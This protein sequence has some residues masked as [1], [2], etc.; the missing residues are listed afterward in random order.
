MWR[1][2][3]GWIPRPWPNGRKQHLRDLTVELAMMLCETSPKWCV[4]NSECEVYTHIHDGCDS[5]CF[6]RYECA[7][8]ERYIEQAEAR[9]SSG[10]K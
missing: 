2:L 4:G 6:M 7:C 8:Y 3:T 5:P 1:A 9:L 10:L